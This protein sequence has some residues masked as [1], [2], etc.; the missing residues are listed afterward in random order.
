MQSLMIT[1]GA[2]LIGSVA[3][4]EKQR[5]AHFGGGSA[6]PKPVCIT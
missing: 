3:I 2:P 4:H 5:F 6:L 1:G